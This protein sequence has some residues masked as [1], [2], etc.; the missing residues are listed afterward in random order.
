MHRYIEPKNIEIR[1]II[2]RNIIRHVNSRNKKYQEPRK[3]SVCHVL[4][5][6][7]KKS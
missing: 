4:V 2:D 3:K 5:I 7:P 6:V 1:M